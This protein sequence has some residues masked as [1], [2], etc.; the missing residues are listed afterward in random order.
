MTTVIVW[1]LVFAPVPPPENGG[2]YYADLL[3]FQHEF[4]SEQ[5]CDTA[6]KR[7]TN[8]DRDMW[9]IKGVKTI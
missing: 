4:A 2:V 6:A 8:K 1:F 9:C 3:G 5:E 7:L